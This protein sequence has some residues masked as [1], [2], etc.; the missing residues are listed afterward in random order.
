[1]AKLKAIFTYQDT[2]GKKQNGL[3]FFFEKPAHR[4]SYRLNF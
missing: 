3:S 4:K 1:M 2:D